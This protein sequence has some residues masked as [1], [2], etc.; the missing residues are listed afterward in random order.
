MSV[1][2]IYQTL[3][4]LRPGAGNVLLAGLSFCSSLCLAFLRLSHGLVSNWNLLHSISQRVNITSLFQRD[5]VII[6][7]A[8][9]I[10]EV[11]I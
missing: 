7:S 9:N 10:F 2:M 5:N 1:S 11:V 4:V 6:T 3:N 8:C